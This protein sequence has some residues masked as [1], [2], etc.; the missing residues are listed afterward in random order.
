[1]LRIPFQWIEFIFERFESHWK[2]V[3][4]GFENFEL[5]FECF[6]HECLL[7]ALNLHSNASNQVWG[8]RNCI[9]M[10]PNGSNPFQMLQVT[11]EW[12]EFGFE[13]FDAFGMVR[14][15]IRV[16]RISFDRLEFAFEC[17]ESLSNGYN[18]D[19]N[20][21]NPFRMIIIWIG[22]LRIPFETFEFT[23][24]CFESLSNSSNLYSNASNPF[25][26]G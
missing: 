2:W 17:F 5:A 10:L 1:M 22:M 13:C 16:L 24:E 21:S 26:N 3:E 4:F 15:C 19:S 18:L 14:I 8:V 20:A 9:R 23:F 12:L 11:F 6:D 25:E 7:N